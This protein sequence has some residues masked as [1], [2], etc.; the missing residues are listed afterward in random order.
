[1]IS[2]K[3]IY[4]C[5][6]CTACE[7]ICSAKSITMKPDEQGFL[8][9]S[10]VI[11][12]CVECGLC[13][14]VCPIIF[15]DSN[16]LEGLPL[17]VFA[18][19]HK[20]ETILK[21]SSSGGVFAAFVEYFLLQGGIVYGAE[22]DENFVVIHR[23]EETGDGAIKFRGSKYV[24]SDIRGIYVEIRK[25]LKTG[26]KVLFSGTPCQVEGLKCFLLKPYENL[27]TVDIVC[28]GVPS[29][30]VFA[31][32]V[33]FV[34]KNSFFKLTG[35]NMKDKTFGWGYQDLR[36]YFGKGKSQFNTTLSKL[37]N[38]I[39]YSHLTTRPS[40]HKCRFTNFHRPG[41]IT[42]G[43]FWGIENAHPDF[44][45]KDGV[46]LC[47]INT[48]MG[49]KVWGQTKN[50][51]IYI[52][53]NISKCKQPNLQYPV[54]EPSEKNEFAFLYKHREGGYVIKKFFGID[55]GK[56]FK[57]NILFVLKSIIGKNL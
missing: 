57:E 27:L 3:N 49:K 19:H 16:K 40:C 39:Y 50:R 28:H 4:D 44:V 18:L 53:S 13:E 21:S 24:Q 8:Y 35:I 47:M 52:E 48:E 12:T 2:S 54:C 10:V 15:R 20:D 29:P 17:Q 41:D 51:F 42:I 36:L 9:P 32:Y 30:N 22:Y 23:G 37:W 14:K 34:Q 7:S 11:S 31:D 5:C 1:M 25:H 26:R 33:K 56:L 6:G 45:N 38:K 55:R 43:D 46:S